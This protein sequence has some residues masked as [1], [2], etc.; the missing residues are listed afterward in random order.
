MNDRLAYDT[1]DNPDYDDF[2]RILRALMSKTWPLGVGDEL[3]G[4]PVTEGRLHSVRCAAMA[5]GIDQRRLR[6]ILSADGIVPKE[7]LPD[8]W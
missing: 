6:K 7:G 3:L 2:R 4:E 5:T 1:I 8:A